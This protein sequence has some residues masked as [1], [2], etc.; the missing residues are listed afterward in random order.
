[1][2][3]NNESVNR[4]LYDLL[5]TRGYNPISRDS[6]VSQAGKTV[7]PEEADVFRFTFKQNGKE[8]DDA[9]ATIDKARTLIVYYDKDIADTAGEK[10]SSAPYDDSWYGLLKF[11]KKWAHSR[12]LSFSLEPKEKLDNDMAQRTYMKKKEQIA[13]GYYPMGKAA[14]YNDNIPT[15][16][17]I[18][19]HTRQIHEGEQ[20]YRNIA[21]IFLENAQGER[22]LAPTIKPGIAQIYAR[23]L[24]E[25]GVPNDERWN[26]I[27]SLCEE[28]GKMAGFVRAVRGN[29]F[30][31]SAQR[32]VEAGLNHYTNLRETLGKMRG[33]RGYNAYFES[34]TPTLMENEGDDNT[35][36]E[37]FVQETLDP[38]IESVMPILNKLSKNLGEMKQV[39]EL[40]EWA[41][42]LTEA[43]GAETAAHNTAI[44]KSRLNALDLDE[45]EIDDAEAAK[46]KMNIPAYQRKAKGVDWRVTQQDLAKVPA[47]TRTTSQGLAAH[48]KRT[49]LDG[50]DVAEGSILKSIKRG[51]QGWDKNAVGPGGEK[52]GDPKEI[53]RRNR[54]HDDDTLQRLHKATSE[55]LGF[56]FGDPNKA[57]KHSPLDLQ[58]RVLDREMRKRGLGVEGVAEGWK[59][60]VAAG[61]TAAAMATGAGGVVLNPA[62]PIGPKGQTVANPYPNKATNTKSA[63]DDAW[64]KIEK[65]KAADKQV[66]KEGVAEG[67]K[68]P[69]DAA[70]HA[71]MAAKIKKMLDDTLADRGDRHGNPDPQRLTRAYEYHMEKAKENQG[72]AEGTLD[73]RHAPDTDQILQHLTSAFYNMRNYSDS[74]SNFETVE[75]VYNFL[76][77]S[78]KQGDYEDFMR[79]YEGALSRY[80]DAATELIDEMFADA[81][82]DTR[83]ATIE[84]FLD[85]VGTQGVAEDLDANQKRVRQLGPTEKVG[86]KGAVGKLVGANESVEINEMDSE[87]YKGSRDDVDEL[88]KKKEGTGKMVKPEEVAKDAK[89]KLDKAMDKAHK[90]DVKEG[91]EDL[92][93]ILR[94]IKK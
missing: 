65:R 62:R 92:E 46:K 4:E 34:W 78:L 42:K 49:G 13:E 11:F 45:D 41:D 74:Y 8:I 81:G 29:Q 28:Y 71:K 6:D 36:N 66:K 24:A 21:K 9:W 18:L 67:Y 85:K 64:T 58:K 84:D 76:R 91:Q 50:E 51:L 25:G 1:M 89:E 70:G 33:H 44:E 40:E 47:G 83:T 75:R 35:L 19:Q 22:I 43:P 90:K 72:V 93:A 27:K 54:A 79:R 12:Q 88:G 61:L 57:T 39:K 52:L 3:K 63:E 59:E 60:K 26:H 69:T 16:K 86:P 32:L 31:E 20:R 80:P 10:S 82:L 68:E 2:P 14:S 17:I 5:D 94:I 7:P 30:N 53:V 56:P 48:A 15:V 87:G 37:L 77:S 55:P 73:T 38:R 23:H